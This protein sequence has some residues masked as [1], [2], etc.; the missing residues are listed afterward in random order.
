MGR[1]LEFDRELA[2]TKATELFWQEGYINTSLRQLLA[3]M[4]MGESSFYNTFKS[5][6][7]LYLECL[8]HYN[9][10]MMAERGELIGGD[11]PAR[12]RLHK[13]FLAA[14][15]DCASNQQSGCLMANS[16]TKEVLEDKDLR[17]YIFDGTQ[18]VLEMFAAIITEGMEQGD[19]RSNIDNAV[20]PRILLTYL[21]GMMRL[22][23]FNFD[24]AAQQAEAE[25]FL[26]VVL[27]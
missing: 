11:A 26:V 7:A 4:S 8:G 24:S 13:F 20:T 12:E 21:H 9:N 19:F 1:N 10:V 14:V 2:L 27:D 16:F 5:K 23:A 18:G 17:Q 3:A 25:Q 22:S 15:T 6:K